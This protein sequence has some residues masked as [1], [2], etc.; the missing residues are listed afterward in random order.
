MKPCRACNAPLENGAD[1]CTECGALWTPLAAPRSPL[2]SPPSPVD[3]G[4]ENAAN[5]RRIV[6]GF[7]IGY[8][9][10]VSLLIL[11]IWCNDGNAAG[12]MLLTVFVLL[13]AYAVPC[14]RF[15]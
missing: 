12:K 8:S 6:R 1:R 5:D 11:A 3:P 4:A 15:L 14:G 2:V 7:L 10:F 13:V 9:I